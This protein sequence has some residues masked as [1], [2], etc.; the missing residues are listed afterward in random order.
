MAF[1]SVSVPS[2]SCVFSSECI[3][4]YGQVNSYLYSVE[5]TRFPCR[6]LA[7]Y[8]HVFSCSQNSLEW[9]TKNFPGFVWENRTKIIEPQGKEFIVV[10]E[11]EDSFALIHGSEVTYYKTNL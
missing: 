8:K 11:P 3:L 2:S 4:Y 9:M 10:L 7:A 5:Y 1:F 6:I